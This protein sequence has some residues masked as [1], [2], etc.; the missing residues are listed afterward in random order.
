MHRLN[1]RDLFGNLGFEEQYGAD[2]T[3]DFI[4]YSLLL[5]Y[6]C[7]SFPAQVCLE[8]PPPIFIPRFIERSL[9]IQ[10]TSP[11]TKFFFCYI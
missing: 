4:I 6:S 1:P 9:P 3:I 8:F 7:E 5:D 2:S 11:T 10:K